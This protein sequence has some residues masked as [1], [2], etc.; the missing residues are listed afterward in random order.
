MVDFFRTI[1]KFPKVFFISY[2]AFL[3]A[4][5]LAASFSSQEI[6]RR[7]T[8]SVN[9]VS[10][11]F[12]KSFF[13][14]VK[15]AFLIFSLP[16]AIKAAYSASISS[17]VGCTGCIVIFFFSA[18][19]CFVSGCFR[20]SSTTTGVTF[21]GCRG[22]A[23]S[24]FLSSSPSIDSSI[25]I[26]ETVVSW[27]MLTESFSS[28]TG[29][30]NSVTL[31]FV[32]TLFPCTRKAT[33]DPTQ[34]NIVITTDISTPFLFFLRGWEIISS[35]FTIVRSSSSSFWSDC[36]FGCITVVSSS[37]ASSPSVLCNL[38]AGVSSSAGKSNAAIISS[39]VWKRSAGMICI[40][41]I[42][43]ASVLGD[44]SLFSSDGF[45]KGRVARKIDS[46]GIFPVKRLYMVAPSE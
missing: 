21:S 5:S 2:W 36:S 12:V 19:T 30:I 6:K 14:F 24:V 46:V 8:S 28:P 27:G 22:I 20:G 42:M 45:C 33:A 25:F 7:T 13:A 31:G 11:A 9:L 32:E 37:S 34:A 17:A 44:I 23:V 3:S 15:S 10:F 40:A 35:L 38:F 4:K 16:E 1:V 26:S 39:T 18:G 41:L 29:L 43:A